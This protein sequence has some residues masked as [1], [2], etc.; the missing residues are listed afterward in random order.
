MEVFLTRDNKLV[1][2]ECAARSGGGMMDQAFKTLYDVSLKESVA[3]IFLETYKDNK[4]KIKNIITII[5][6]SVLMTTAG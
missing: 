2:S 1:F 5:L 6:I 3:D 4:P